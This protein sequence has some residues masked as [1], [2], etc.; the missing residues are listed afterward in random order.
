MVQIGKIPKVGWTFDDVES[1]N[2]NQFLSGAKPTQGYKVISL[3]TWA[4]NI[5]NIDIGE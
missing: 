5:L 1:F 4:W 2:D 3:K